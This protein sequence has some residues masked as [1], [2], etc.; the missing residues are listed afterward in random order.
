MELGFFA[1]VF[2]IGGVIGFL[3]GMRV[4]TTSWKRLTV[5]GV[6]YVNPQAP[7]GQGLF[8]EQ[9][10]AADDIAATKYAVFETV[11][12]NRDSRK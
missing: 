1:L 9:F 7:E 3:V 8:L 2:L 6:L 12:I 5:K 4:A 11:V 10:T